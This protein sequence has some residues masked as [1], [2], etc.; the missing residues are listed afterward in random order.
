MNNE[1]YEQWVR[2]SKGLASVEAF[3]IPVLQGLGHVDC[4]LIP[5]DERFGVALP[6]PHFSVTSAK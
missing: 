1:R 2:A 5:Q 6:E 3:M 4:Q